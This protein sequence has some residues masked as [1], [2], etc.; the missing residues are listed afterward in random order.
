MPDC[1]YDCEGNCILDEDNDGI[2]DCEDEC[3]PATALMNDDAYKLSVESYNVGALG[4]TY[5]FYVNAED[6]TD[7]FSAVFGNNESP[8]VINT[9]EGIYNDVFNTAWN[10]SGIN[11]ALFGFFPDLEFD[12]YATIGLDGPA[13][14]VP[15]ANDP[16]LVQD[17]SLPPRSADI[18][19]QGEPA[20]M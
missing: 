16:S 6:A 8:L 10:A 1:G 18:S 20:S 2:C 4:T 14:G 15:G 17:V 5:R 7:K 9:P 19:L 11:A 13:A 12:S 3:L